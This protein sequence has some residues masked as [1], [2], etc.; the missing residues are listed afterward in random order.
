MQYPSYTFVNDSDKVV[1]SFT[2]TPEEMAEKIAE[3]RRNPWPNRNV[4]LVTTDVTVHKVIHACAEFPPGDY[5]EIQV[6]ADG[7]III[8][9]EPF[10]YAIAMTELGYAD[11][12]MP[13]HDPMASF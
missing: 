3:A 13:A 8:A 5:A 12:D 4:A 11:F 6:R 2:V 1:A 9:T 7:R 10:P